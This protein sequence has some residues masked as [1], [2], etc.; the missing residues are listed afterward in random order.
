MDRRIDLRKCLVL[1]RNWELDNNLLTRIKVYKRKRN[2][3]T[4]N[5]DRFL[6][7]K[8][9][10]PVHC[11]CST[12]I[13]LKSHGALFVAW[14]CRLGPPLMLNLQSNP[15]MRFQG[16][17]ILNWPMKGCQVPSF[18]AWFWVLGPTMYDLFL[19]LIYYLWQ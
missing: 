15:S 19:L 2:K 1:G 13:F 8:W 11:P 9:K 14:W 6:Q 18:N 7:P 3:D 16:E 12:C 5:I 17:C 10:A 4:T